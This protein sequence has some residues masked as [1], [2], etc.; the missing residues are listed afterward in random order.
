MYSVTHRKGC[1]MEGLENFVTAVLTAFV[2]LF[3][4]VRLLLR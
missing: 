1:P 2:V 4:W 3:L